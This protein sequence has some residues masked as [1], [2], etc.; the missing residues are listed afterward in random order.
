MGVP[1]N[2][3]KH[4]RRIPVTSPRTPVRHAYCCTG[5][6][7]DGRSFFATNESRLDGRPSFVPQPTK[8]CIDI[9]FALRSQRCSRSPP[10]LKHTTPPHSNHPSHSDAST[11]RPPGI[12]SSAYLP[13]TSRATASCI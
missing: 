13:H 2:S 5:S 12:A 1:L 11:R 6:R 9:D 4:E 8:P 10:S 3:E 7:G